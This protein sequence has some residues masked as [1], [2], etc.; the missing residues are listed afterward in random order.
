[1][2]DTVVIVPTFMEGVVVTNDKGECYIERRYG[3]YRFTLDKALEYLV[4]ERKEYL[5]KD[6]VLYNIPL[7]DR[8][9]E[10]GILAFGEELK[11]LRPG[12]E[13]FAK[14]VNGFVYNYKDVQLADFDIQLYAAIDDFTIGGHTFHGLDELEAK[15]NLKAS[16]SIIG[17]CYFSEGDS[18]TAPFVGELYERYPCFDSS[19]YATE[20]HYYENYIVRDRAITR[21]ELQELSATKGGGNRKKLTEQTPVK[22]L[23]M[24]YY[25]G[26]S[27]F[28]LVGTVK[29]EG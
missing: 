22:M 10:I 7:R 17:G 19:D 29:P 15:I 24:V 13:E 2:K 26:D 21:E 16:A 18:K 23:P 11:Q 6:I 28:I 1:M 9:R 14:Y 4:A 5:L 25:D 8:M 3:Q 12:D 20:N 27:G